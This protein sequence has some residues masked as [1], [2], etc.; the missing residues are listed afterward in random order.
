MKRT[1]LILGEI[2]RNH[3]RWIAVVIEKN[4]NI[5]DSAMNVVLIQI[6]EGINKFIPC[7]SLLISYLYIDSLVEVT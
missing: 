4:A 6:L 1:R 7:L 5:F 3:G 2:N